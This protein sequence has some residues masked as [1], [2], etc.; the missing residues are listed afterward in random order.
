M[1]ALSF[2]EKTSKSKQQ[3]VYVLSG[4]EDFL[5]RRV[6][7]LLH[8]AMFPTAVK[9]LVVLAPHIF[10]EDLSV[11]SIRITRKTYLTTD[12]PTKLARHHQ[13]VASAFWGWNDIW[14]AAEFRAWNIESEIEGM[15][16][17]IQGVQGTISK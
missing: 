6:S 11:D 5:K 3:S 16:Y 7:A 2:L 12:L 15:D 17:F 8:A 9:G 4:D 10:V 14:L 1:D 13:D